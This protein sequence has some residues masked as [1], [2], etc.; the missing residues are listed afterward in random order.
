MT[1][2]VKLMA[3]INEK[4]TDEQRKE[5]VSRG[6]KNPLSATGAILSPMFWTIDRESNM[7]LIECGVHRD[8]PDEYYFVF[9]WKAEQYVIS[10]VMETKSNTAIWNKEV[11]ASPYVFSAS[12]PYV[13]DLRNALS[14]FK[15]DGSTD[16]LNE[17]S[18]AIC[19]F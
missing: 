17:N 5:F 4:L 3:F 19:N 18:K 8:Y 11:Q 14:V 16:Q 9:L 1:K 2:D 6:I 7:C 12:A 15:F 13:D 10:L